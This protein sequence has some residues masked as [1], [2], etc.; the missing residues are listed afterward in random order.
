MIKLGETSPLDIPVIFL[1]WLS[2]MI[3]KYYEGTDN[4]PDAYM[5]IY[6]GLIFSLMFCVLMATIDKI[7]IFGIVIVFVVHVIWK[8]IIHDNKKHPIGHMTEAMWI[9]YKVDIILR[10]F[11]FILASPF[12]TLALLR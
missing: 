5:H 1:K 9:N 10:C 8:E 4:S 6:T 11:G 3:N 12:I 2:P 7:F